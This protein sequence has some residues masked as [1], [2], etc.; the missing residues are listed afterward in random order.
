MKRSRAFL[1]FMLLLFFLTAHGQI[2]PDTVHI[3]EIKVLAKRK[4]EE[5]G[6]KITRPD[7]LQIISSLTTDLSELLANYSPVFI[8]SHGRGSQA[9]ASFRGTAA[10]H[11]QILWNGMNLNSPMRGVSDLSL[12]PVFFVDE[13]YIL[14]GGSSMIKGSG[15]LGGSIHLENNPQWHSGVALEGLAETGS[16]HSGKSFFKLNAGGTQF[17]STTR[18]FYD[19][20]EN[21]FPFYNS[22]VIPKKTDTLS[23]AGYRKAGNCR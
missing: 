13:V 1:F 6:L 14:H 20:S 15:A 2:P 21:N 9:T 23:N 5:A 22:G 19:A 12:F 10:T 17:Q 4:I 18:F 16:F 3:R 8:K 7:S 11:T